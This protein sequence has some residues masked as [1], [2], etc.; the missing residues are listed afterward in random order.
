MAWTPLIERFDALPLI[1]AG[2]LLRRTEPSSVTVW[3][4]LKEPRYVS[5]RIY[6]KDDKGELWRQYEGTRHTVRLGDHLHLVAVTAYAAN[7]E[8]RLTWGEHYYYDLFFQSDD[9]QLATDN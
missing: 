2:P 1:L 8:E 5:L 4:A 3:L 6:R 9:A 7:E